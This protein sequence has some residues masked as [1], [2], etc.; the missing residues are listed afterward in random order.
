VGGFT[1]VLAFGRTV[2]SVVTCE[3]GITTLSYNP[4]PSQNPR[5]PG[6]SPLGLTTLN[7]KN[8]PIVVTLGGIGSCYTSLAFNPQAFYP[9]YKLCNNSVNLLYFISNYF[10]HLG[11]KSIGLPSTLCHSHE[12][13]NVIFCPH[14][15]SRKICAASLFIPFISSCFIFRLL[16]HLACEWLCH[17]CNIVTATKNFLFAK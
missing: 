10:T 16:P 4:F 7:R 17:P 2:C 13:C 6:M 1:L 3:G 12:V 11:T 14:L 9:C 15:S 8:H 5:S